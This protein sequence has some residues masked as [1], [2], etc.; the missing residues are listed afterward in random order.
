MYRCIKKSK[1]V[2]SNAACCENL[3]TATWQPASKLALLDPTSCSRP[4]CSP[5]PLHQSCYVWPCY[6]WPT[7]NST[8]RC[9]GMPAIP[10]LGLCTGSSFHPGF[11]PSFSSLRKLPC[12][13]QPYRKPHAEKSWIFLPFKWWLTPYIPIFCPWPSLQVTEAL[14]HSSTATSWET[15]IQNQQDKLLPD[16]WP[17]TEEMINICYFKVLN[18]GTSL[19]VQWLRICLAMQGT[20]VQF[21]IKEQRSH[22]PWDN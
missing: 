5:L 19:V 2:Q 18:W 3:K 13:E 17:Q 20:W 15:L 1:D 8:W 22:V 12:C 11:S 9:D 4:S 14:A 7:A 16:S 10:E 21:L 6:V